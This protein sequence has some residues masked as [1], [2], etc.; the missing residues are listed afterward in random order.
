M[1]SDQ[2]SVA[3]MFDAI[4]AKYDRANRL[5]SF[6]NDIIW[7]NKLAKAVPEGALSLIDL[8]TGT[9]DQ[10][11]A[12]LKQ[13]PT[14]RAVGI[15]FAARML[16]VGAAKLAKKGL[17]AE[18]K[19]ASAL[20]LPYA[21]ASFDCATISF[22]IRNVGDVEKCLKEM[23]RVLKP[24]GCALI[25]EFSLPH[26]LLRPFYLLYLRHI[27]PR[28][29]GLITHQGQAYRYLNRTIERFP[30]GENFLALMR[31]AGFVSA[32]AHPLTGGIATLYKGVVT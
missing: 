21:D 27:L 1:T 5:L 30:Y 22:G 11:I 2:Q 17:K 18:L 20:E 14:L 6:G 23:R 8:A 24:D 19:T 10:L 9:C 28:L 32:E 26:P 12:I 7:R 4:A 25:L 29:G 15:D 13:H 3:Q 16:E 31:N